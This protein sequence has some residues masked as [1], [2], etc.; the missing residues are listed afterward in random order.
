MR[1][2]HELR[3]AML[4]AG[5]RL[6]AAQAV[7]LTLIQ[8]KEDRKGLLEEIRVARASVDALAKDYLHA[9]R[10]NRQARTGAG[11]CLKQIC[12]NGRLNQ[13]GAA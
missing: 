9:V 1:T 13:F 12:A 5:D 6:L 11:Y 4:N 7:E 2:N 10:T 8:E 3:S